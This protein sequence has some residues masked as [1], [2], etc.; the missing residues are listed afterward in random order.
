MTVPSII[1][2]S[3]KFQLLQTST[4]VLSGPNGVNGVWDTSTGTKTKWINVLE[5]SSGMYHG[6]RFK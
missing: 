6:C 1:F 4:I 3:M 2:L 5:P